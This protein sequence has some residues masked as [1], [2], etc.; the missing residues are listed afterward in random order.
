RLAL[1]RL[2]RPPPRRRDDPERRPPPDF[3]AGCGQDPGRARPDRHRPG[4]DPDHSGPDQP[5]FGPAAAWPAPAA[6][7]PDGDG[8]AILVRP[9]ESRISGALASRP[10]DGAVM[11][12]FGGTS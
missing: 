10:R 2:A 3:T 8:L 7:C 11:K 1:Q 12:E 4:F 6:A 5:D 9:G